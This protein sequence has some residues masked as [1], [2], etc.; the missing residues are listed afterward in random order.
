MKLD[1][2]PPSSR[3]S[4]DDLPLSDQDA[5]S[6]QNQTPSFFK[7][8]T[9]INLPPF[10]FWKRLLFF[11]KEG[12]DDAITTSVCY[13]MDVATVCLNRFP[14]QEETDVFVSQSSA[15]EGI[16]GVGRLLGLG[17][18][19]GITSADP[20]SRAENG[21]RRLFLMNSI[22]WRARAIKGLFVIPFCYT[23]GVVVGKVAGV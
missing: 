10:R 8:P 16:R 13:R 5:Y 23:I 2:A 22:N 6:D 20:S 4:E 9:K 17:I 12:H 15:L 21:A 11:S 3:P 14:T 19:F 1:D 7:Y 18:G